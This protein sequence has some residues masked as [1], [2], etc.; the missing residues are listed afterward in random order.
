MRGATAIALCVAVIAVIAGCLWACTVCRGPG[1]EAFAAT[2]SGPGVE[3]RFVRLSD[4]AVKCMNIAEVEVY[5]DRKGASANMARGKLVTKS[6]SWGND[7][8]PARNLVDGTNSM[9]HTSCTDAP[10]MMID[11][12]RLQRVA[13]V[14]VRNRVDCCQSRL[15]GTVVELLDGNMT[16]VFKSKPLTDAML[17]EVTPVEARFTQ[18]PGTPVCATVQLVLGSTSDATKDIAIKCR[19]ACARRNDGS[20]LLAGVTGNDVDKTVA[21]KCCKPASTVELV[22]DAGIPTPRCRVPGLDYGVVDNGMYVSNGCRGVFK[23]LDGSASSCVP[24]QEHSPDV[25]F[26]C[27]F[28]LGPKEKPIT[29]FD[30]IK[31]RDKADALA[32]LQPGTVSTL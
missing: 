11:L 16:P 1:V 8:F 24:P 5:A 17:Q 12:G 15:A 6:S 21:C 22:H 29:Q 28:T 2:Q 20:T 26:V 14:R 3:A 7:A 23:W 13:M 27:P 10:W 25:P 9:A 31:A 18:G 4:V 30:L 32:A 19:D